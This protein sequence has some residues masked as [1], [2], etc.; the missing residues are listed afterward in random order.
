MQAPVSDPGR[1][2]GHILQAGDRERSGQSPINVVVNC[3]LTVDRDRLGEVTQPRWPLFGRTRT[4]NGAAQCASLSSIS[5]GQRQNE[6]VA[7]A[8]GTVYGSDGLGSPALRTQL[9]AVCQ[10]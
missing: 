5:A 2:S 7:G 1:Q 9:T 8:R 6:Q 4:L 3:P 10:L